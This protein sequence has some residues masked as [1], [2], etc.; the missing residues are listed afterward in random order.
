MNSNLHRFGERVESEVDRLGQECEINPPTLTQFDA[1]GN[2]VD[3][4]NTC[5]AWKNMKT[6]AAEEGL[7]SIGYK[8]K[9]NEFRLV[10]KFHLCKHFF[11]YYSVRW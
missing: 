4:V 1:W 2:R 8:R 6:I 5:S 11:V 3:A 10:L 9:Y 7:I